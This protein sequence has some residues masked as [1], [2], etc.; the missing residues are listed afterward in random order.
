MC[1]VGI[2]PR[3]CTGNLY[4]VVTGPNNGIYKAAEQHCVYGG[5]K[6]VMSK[7]EINI[8]NISEN[9]QLCA[10]AFL[11]DVRGAHTIGVK[12]VRAHLNERNNYKYQHTQIRTP[13]YQTNGSH[14]FTMRAF[15]QNLPALEPLCRSNYTHTH[16]HTL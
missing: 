8:I 6:A 14:N 9:T 3:Q 10:R 7:Y 11:G 5:N 16:T 4:N 15:S 1:V 13:D 2:D 12:V